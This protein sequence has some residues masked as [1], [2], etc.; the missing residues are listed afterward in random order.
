MKMKYIDIYSSILFTRNPNE[1]THQMKYYL[2][3]V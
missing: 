1:D 3:I 2:F